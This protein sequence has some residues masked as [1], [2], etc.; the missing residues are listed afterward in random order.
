MESG[1]ERNTWM[2]DYFALIGDGVLHSDNGDTRCKVA[3]HMTSHGKH[4]DGSRMLCQYLETVVDRELKKWLP[5]DAT[6]EEKFRVSLFPAVAPMYAELGKSF[7]HISTYNELQWSLLDINNQ[8]TGLETLGEIREHAFHNL[9]KA[10]VITAGIVLDGVAFLEEYGIPPHQYTDEQKMRMKQDLATIHQRLGQIQAFNGFLAPAIEE[11]FT[12][13]NL[14][15]ETCGGE[16]HELVA[17]SHHCLACVYEC[18]AEHLLSSKEVVRDRRVARFGGYGGQMG[19]DIPLSNYRKSAEHY[20]ASGVS[21]AG[22]LA[23]ICQRKPEEIVTVNKLDAIYVNIS[24][25]ETP[26]SET[27]RKHFEYLKAA[28][29]G[30]KARL[31]K[32]EKRIETI[33][34][35]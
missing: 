15:I 7:L 34:T 1:D 33:T 22:H 6:D 21:Y 19:D 11:Y 27:D 8:T 13:L 28:L 16:F 24:K 10:R 18:Y 2:G 35:K 30:A 17:Q 14:N 29:N 26:Y 23:I 20:L 3:F 32:I 9:E 5:D 4:N 31:D 12:A 25:I